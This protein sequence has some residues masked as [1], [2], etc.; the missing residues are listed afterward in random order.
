MEIDLRM[1]AL[2]N[3]GLVGL[4]EA[5]ECGSSPSSISRKL[6]SGAW[7]RLAP[8]VYVMREL[9]TPNSHLAAACMALPGAV[10]SH[11][12]AALLHGL[13]GIDG[14]LVEVS[15]PR[16][17]TTR[18]HLVVHRVDDLA[19]VD[20]SRIEGIPTTTVTRTLVD[21]GAV[22]GLDALERATESTLRHGTTS[23]RRLLWRVEALSRRGRPGPSSLR[24]VLSRRAGKRATGSEF[25][26]R[27][28]QCLR[29]RG[30]PDPVRQH[31]VRAAGRTACIDLAYPDQRVAIELDG[32]AAHGGPDAF[33]ADRRR[34]NIV[35]LAGWNVLRFTWRDLT[36][37]PDGLAR[38]VSTALLLP[39]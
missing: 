21:L 8:Q 38:E 2:A 5:L 39:A 29:D 9:L 19:E 6:A 22:V 27:V 15:V 35:V 13:D 37:R 36:E 7:A 16:S 28:V 24:T 25:E 10:A 26:T 32:W 12:A 3:H 4:R 17:V 23:E 20:I 11:R 14:A 31:R 30:L 34:Q 33:V 1:V 18:R